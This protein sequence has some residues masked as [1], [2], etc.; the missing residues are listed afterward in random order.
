MTIRLLIVCP[1]LLPGRCSPD[2]CTTGFGARCG[3]LCVVA[4]TVFSHWI[5]DLLTHRP[6]LPLGFGNTVYVGLGLWNSLWGTL[7]LELG[8]FFAGLVLYLKCTRARDTLRFVRPMVAPGH[9]RAD[10]CG[11]HLRST[12]SQ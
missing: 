10:L 9:S 7:L 5:L 12:T 11:E 6:D 4:G 2:S 8:L 3:T 1:V